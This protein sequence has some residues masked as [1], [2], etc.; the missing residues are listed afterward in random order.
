MRSQFERSLHEVL[1]MIG[2]VEPVFRRHIFNP[3]M[4]YA[5]VV[6]DHIHY[7]L[8]AAVVAFGYQL[9]ILFVGAET[10]INFIV[11]GSSIAVV[12]TA[13]HVVF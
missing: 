11:I 8:D 5:A 3:W 9:L 6:E 2:I 13:G 7:N 4:F 12:R 1:F 10:R